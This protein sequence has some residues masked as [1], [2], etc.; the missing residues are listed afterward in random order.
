MFRSNIDGLADVLNRL[1]D[2]LR[3]VENIDERIVGGDNIRVKK[4][5]GSI[6]IDADPAGDSSAPTGETCSF[7]F[8]SFGQAENSDDGEGSFKVRALGGTVNGLIPANYADIGSFSPSQTYFVTLD[9]NTDNTGITSV[10]YTT[11]NQLPEIKPQ[12]AE[13]LPPSQ[14]QFF[15]CL[16]TEGVVTSSLCRNIAMI[17]Q[18]AYL[19]KSEEIIK[20]MYTWQIDDA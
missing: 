20:T 7:I 4:L 17:P 16:I 18:V 5:G 11:H 15:A 12:Y 19:D 6:V 3:V 2:R 10:Q 14:I 8:S 13:G 1:D 9:V